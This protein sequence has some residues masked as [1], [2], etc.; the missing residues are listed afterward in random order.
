[1]EK[2]KL[3]SYLGQLI[4][5]KK[6]HLQGLMIKQ[7]TEDVDILIKAIES[8]IKEIDEFE[9]MD[10]ETERR[11]NEHLREKENDISEDYPVGGMV[12]PYDIEREKEMTEEE[13]KKEALEDKIRDDAEEG[14]KEKEDE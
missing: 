14:L 7:G 2:Q 11:Q 9:K 3:E 1:M 10:K 6:G 12:E 13:E 4:D 8:R 5:L